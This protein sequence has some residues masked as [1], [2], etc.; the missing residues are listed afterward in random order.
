MTWLANHVGGVQITLMIAVIALGLCAALS[1]LRWFVGKSCGADLGT[2]AGRRNQ[3]FI[4]GGFAIL[5]LVSWALAPKFL[6]TFRFNEPPAPVCICTVQCTSEAINVDCEVCAAEGADLTALCSA[7]APSD[8]DEPNYE[9]GYLLP[10]SLT[11]D[12]IADFLNKVD[13]TFTKRSLGG[14]NRTARNAAVAVYAAEHNHTPFQDPVNYPIVEWFPEF[15]QLRDSKLTLDQ[16]LELTEK[17]FDALDQEMVSNIPFTIMILDNM[18]KLP[19]VYKYN[20]EWID[21]NLV[22]LNQMYDGTYQQP[23]DAASSDIELAKIPTLDSKY[24][25]LDYLVVSDPN[26]LG[27]ERLAREEWARLC[28][29]MSSALRTYA[30]R[31]S[32]AMVVSRTADLSWHNPP[33]AEDSLVRMVI[34][35]KNDNRDWLMLSV[36]SKQIDAEDKLD[37]EYS[38]IGINPEDSRFG[39]F[40]PNTPDPKPEE[41]KPEDPPTTPT[42][43]VTPKTYSVSTVSKDTNGNILVPQAVYKSGLKNGASCTVSLP[44]TPNGYTLK[45]VVVGSTDK[46]LSD[47]TVTINKANVLVT[48]IYEKNPE[49]KV[50]DYALTSDHGYYDSRNKWQSFGTRAEGRYTAG[51]RYSVNADY[52]VPSGYYAVQ[53]TVTGDMPAKDHTVRVEYKQVVTYTLTIK[54]VYSGGGRAAPTYTGEYEYDESYYVPSPDIKG[55][56]PDISVVK[57]EMPNRDKTVTVTYKKDNIPFDGE[58]TKNPG[59]S[60]NNTGDAP[61]GGGN[62]QTTNGE[63]DKQDTK[64][65]ETDYPPAQSGGNNGNGGGGSNPPISANDPNEDSSG[66]GGSDHQIQNP[67]NGNTQGGDPPATDPIP[68]VPGTSGTNQETNKTETPAEKPPENVP[69]NPGW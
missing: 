12:Q 47:V 8:T 35:D 22:I 4:F 54:Y 46:A 15:E 48:F 63:G 1:L 52:K 30:F 28:A 10:V 26:G 14:D 39:I 45:R 3:F 33:V 37:A 66:L 16:R 9:E 56:T 25:G 51:A 18:K 58:G 53:K 62:N 42:T 11:E 67:N 40:T 27:Y 5:A 57:G 17:F 64:P 65:P 41:P 32:G 38:L 50:V 7:A 44:S 23:A 43:P 20:S 61:N 69:V 49:V 2:I 19:Y 31:S 29:R 6:E 68:T 21:G 34:D 60:S 36:M 55:Y 24:K 59:S 13:L